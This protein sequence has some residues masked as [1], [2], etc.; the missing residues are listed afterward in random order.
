MPILKV[1]DLGDEDA[2]RRIRLGTH[3]LY[4]FGCWLEDGRPKGGVSDGRASHWATTKRRTGP[5]KP[6]ASQHV[7]VSRVTDRDD[8]DGNRHQSTPSVTPTVAR[9]PSVG[10]TT[11]RE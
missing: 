11:T 5:T 10:P 7:G 9:D 6:A 1:A 3:M 8:P 4:L 2:I